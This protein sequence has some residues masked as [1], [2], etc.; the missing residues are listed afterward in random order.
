MDARDASAWKDA[1][2]GVHTVKGNAACVGLLRYEAYALNWLDALDAAERAPRDRAS[3]VPALL[4]EVDALEVR[5]KAHAHHALQT[6][7]RL[8]ERYREQD[9]DDLTDDEDPGS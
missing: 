1:R 3:A 9:P 4:L 5:A 8:P 2:R 6:L 7:A